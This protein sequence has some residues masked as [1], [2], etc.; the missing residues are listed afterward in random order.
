MFTI[1]SHDVRKYFCYNE[2]FYVNHEFGFKGNKLPLSYY[3]STAAAKY[4]V[5]CVKEEKST[6][7][8]DV[9]TIHNSNM[10]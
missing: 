9:K 3:K 7:P 2:Q 1:C 8:V 5:L 4:T 6:E 10:L